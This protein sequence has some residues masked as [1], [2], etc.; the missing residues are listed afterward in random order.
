MIFSALA[1]AVLM[2]AAECQ[3][4]F[5]WLALAGLA[6]LCLV[7]QGGAFL[8]DWAAL[9]LFNGLFT[10]LTA[11]W[12]RLT[13]DGFGWFL[14]A[15]IGYEM[16]LAALPAACLWLA[17]RRGRGK[18]ALLF[19]PVFWTLL[20]L[21]SRRALFGISWALAGLP[22]ADYPLAAQIAAI[23]GPEALSFLVVA[24]NVA[25]AL[26]LRQERI[27]RRWALAQG[28]GLTAAALVLG[29]IHGG[30]GPE[31]PT[32]KIAVV[33]PMISQQTRWDIPANRPLLLARMTRLIDRAAAEGPRLIVLPEGAL[34]GLVHRER[35]LAEF[36]TGAVERT[37]RPLLFGSVD[38]D[39]S[40]NFYN[41]AIRIG[42]DGAVDEYRKRRLVPFAEHTPWPFHYRPPWV[43][44]TA[45]DAA[46]LMPLGV[47]SSF[48]VAMCLEDTDPALSRRAVANG[49]TLLIALVNT[50][51]FKGT[52]QAM[53]QLRRARLTAIA[54]GIPMLRAANSGISCS[55]DE[56]GRLLGALPANREAAA[57]L[58]VTTLTAATVYAAV[59][60]AGVLAM[61]GLWIALAALALEIGVPQAALPARKP[62]HGPRRRTVPGVL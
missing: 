35:D 58:P 57:V 50:E 21:L 38:S 53:V 7:L 59:G 1:S 2:A 6:P 15:A 12:I 11:Q 39:D 10:A 30:S 18:R 54:D 19:L 60:D 45:G 52:S 44:F 46:T 17:G 8:S 41:A 34:P 9:A 55:L 56:H 24:V 20:E 26:S 23:G 36:A 31:T 42:T 14:L 43:Q 28:L 13:G 3:T 47:V 16:L 37:R 48:A 32:A 33:Q 4:G 51:N 29:L 25:L 62:H 40:G 49:A 22:L 61:L 5:G 27:L